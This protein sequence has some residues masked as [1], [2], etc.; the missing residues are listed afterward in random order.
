NIYWKIDSN[1]WAN[2][3][4]PER[5]TA[6]TIAQMEAKGGDHGIILMHD[7]WPRSPDAFRMILD[8]IHKR[9]DGGE[10]LTLVPV[11]AALAQANG[12]VTQKAQ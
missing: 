1:D 10:H 4:N 9:N 7:F 6:L 8:Y 5:T 12:G 3:K 2:K 11:T